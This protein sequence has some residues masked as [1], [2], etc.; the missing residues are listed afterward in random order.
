M[1]AQEILTRYR[2]EP[3][4]FRHKAILINV[5]R[6]AADVSLYEATRYAW[7]MSAKKAGQAEVV[8]AVRQGL[9]VGAFTADQWLP[10][11]E[12]YFPGRERAPGRIGF[13]GREAPPAIRNL[14]LNKRLPEEFRKPGAANPVKYTYR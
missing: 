14:Y 9:I 4:I 1:H 5:N 11:A 13:V 8:L 6:S 2:A 7:K 3:A 10:A 12:E